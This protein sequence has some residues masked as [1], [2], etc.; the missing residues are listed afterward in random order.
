MQPAIESC[1]SRLLVSS[2]VALEAYNSCLTDAEKN[3]TRSFTRFNPSSAKSSCSLRMSRAI[4]KPA[5]ESWSLCS[6]R[7]ASNPL[8]S[9]IPEYLFDTYLGSI[10]PYDEQLSAA[11]RHVAQQ[12]V[13]RSAILYE[14]ALRSFYFPDTAS[15]TITSSSSI[16]ASVATTATNPITTS[17]S[18]TVSTSTT[19]STPVTDVCTITD[20]SPVHGFC[21]AMDICPITAF[22][23]I[24]ASIPVTASGSIAISTSIPASN[25]TTNSTQSCTWRPEIIDPRSHP[26]LVIITIV[27]ATIVIGRHLLPATLIDNC[28]ALAILLRRGFEDA[29]F[30]VSRRCTNTAV[31]AYHAYRRH[32]YCIS[33]LA[34]FLGWWALENKRQ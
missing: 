14:P 17:S 19:A 5:Q 8:L 20:S 25:L 7:V 15:N 3:H 22:S 21:S 31:A 28:I 34:F 24:A 4:W 30:H 10:P 6:S 33:I 18:I 32:R 11:S 12:S 27:L 26:E 29:W 16:K 13:L 23:S 2:D 1:R 9:V